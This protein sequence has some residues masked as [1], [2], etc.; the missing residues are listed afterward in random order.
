MRAA[1][2]SANVVEHKAL[3]VQLSVLGR[4]HICGLPGSKAPTL[5]VGFLLAFWSFCICLHRVLA[6]SRNAPWCYGAFAGLFLGL[7]WHTVH[8]GIAKQGTAH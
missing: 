3:L 7:R 2:L 6:I 5:C 4:D 8:R 1:A